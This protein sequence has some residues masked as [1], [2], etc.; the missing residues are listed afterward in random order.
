[1][2][3]FFATTSG[4]RGIHTSTIGKEQHIM[5]GNTEYELTKNTTEYEFDY[6][7]YKDLD[8]VL[9][10]F[11]PSVR[12]QVESEMTKKLIKEIEKIHT[13]KIS[14]M[15]DGRWRTTVW[16]PEKKKQKCIYSNGDNITTLYEKLYEL[17]FPCKHT[18]K[19]LFYEMC[20]YI[21][22]ITPSEKMLAKQK[23]VREW[24][25]DFVRFYEKS[26]TGIAD[27]TFKEVTL[28]DLCRFLDEAHSQGINKQRH[29]SI[30]TLYIKTMKFAAKNKGEEINN[31]FSMIDYN[32]RDEYPYK[33]AKE[34]SFY[35][36]DERARVL[37]YLDSLEHPTLNQLLIEVIFELSLRL[38]EAIGLR[39]DDFVFD[40]DKDNNIVSG[41]VYIR[42]KATGRIREERTKC[43]SD[44]VLEVKPRLVKI[45]KKIRKLS[46][47]DEYLFVSDKN[48]TKGDNILRTQAG[49]N[50]AWHVVCEK[51]GVKYITPHEIRFSNVTQ[52][53]KDGVSTRI[54]SK[55]CGHS[56]ESMTNHYILEYDKQ[57][58]KQVIDNQRY[59]DDYMSRNNILTYSDIQERIK[60]RP[61]TAYLLSV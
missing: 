5:K 42:G 9:S 50:Y 1:M 41:K 53:S 14:C 59:I 22:S 37:I 12:A 57:I 39:Y 44:R 18:I 45:L 25:Q 28:P 35:T 10:S 17:Y 26:S 6:K 31:L 49:V 38:G 58:P 4:R 43:N 30:K 16:D 23:T 29:A 8:N 34:H 51:A 60:E 13:Q 48:R 24:K 11:S 20:D 56:D 47:S 21:L 54:L 32:N 61:Q 40:V 15:S 36:E 33:D 52:Q 7:I 19:S 55:Q 2:E 27:K 46:W 3:H